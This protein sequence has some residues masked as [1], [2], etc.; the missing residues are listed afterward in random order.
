MMFAVKKFHQF[1]YGRSF[2]IYTDHKPLLGL[3][4]PDKAVPPMASG[5]VQ[6]WALALAAYEYKLVYRPGKENGNADGLSRLPLPDKPETTPI[7]GEI[8]PL[9]E[10]I[11]SSPVNATKLKHW[12]ARDPILSRVFK[13]LQYGWP[14]KVEDN[15]LKPYFTRQNEL[16]IHAGCILWGSRVVISPQGRQHVLATLH[17][18]HMGISKM[19]SLARSYVWWPNLDEALERIVKGCEVCQAHQKEPARAPL[20]PWHWPNRPWARVHVDYAGPF[21][22]KMFLHII[23]AHSIWMDIH[24]V[25]SATTESTIEKLR[26]TFSTH[27]L[28][29]LIVS[30]NGSVFT[31]QEFKTFTDKN[32]IKHVTS[33]PYHPATNG[34][35]ERAVQTFKQGMKK[36][37]EGSAQTKLSRF[38]FGYRITPHTMKK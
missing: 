13:F 35:V 28:Q 22:G 17:K 8:I 3:L 18:T 2:T 30:D 19:K 38:L 10:T 29:E 32:G 9:L 36:Q 4:S 26:I 6:R 12:T 15:A 20:H 14:E 24:I 11:N 23:D 27:G 21:M 25:N 16:S 33:S 34:L 5:R 37:N 1:I 7:P 31:S